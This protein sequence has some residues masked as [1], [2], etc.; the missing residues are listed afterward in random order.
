MWPPTDDVMPY[1]E[2]SDLRALIASGT[3][4]GCTTMSSMKSWKVRSVAFPRAMVI[5]AF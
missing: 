5:R 2:S 3:L 1:F 4:E